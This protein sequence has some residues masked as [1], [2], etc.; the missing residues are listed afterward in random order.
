ME[1]NM[2]KRNG[3]DDEEDL[4]DDWLDSLTGGVKC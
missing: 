3:P 2:N 4:W 1:V